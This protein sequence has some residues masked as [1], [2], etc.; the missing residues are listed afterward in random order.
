MTAKRISSKAQKYIKISDDDVFLSSLLFLELNGDYFFRPN[1]N[2]IF[3]VGRT[4]NCGN[5]YN[6]IFGSSKLKLVVEISAAAM[7]GLRLFF[8]IRARIETLIEHRQMSLNRSIDKFS[9]KGIE[10]QSL[11]HEFYDEKKFLNKLDRIA[12]KRMN[13][14]KRRMISKEIFYP[15]LVRIDTL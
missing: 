10:Y 7:P 11:I 1:N 5:D 6:E 15:H 2:L 3:Y 9:G 4:K 13:P 14:P 8:G 12:I